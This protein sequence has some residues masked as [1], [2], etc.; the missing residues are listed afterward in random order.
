MLN[1]IMLIVIVKS[2][3]ILTVL[4]SK[5]I[6]MFADTG[7]NYAKKLHRLCPGLNVTMFRQGILT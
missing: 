4:L 6:M 5:S 2:V 7:L 1:V 3:V